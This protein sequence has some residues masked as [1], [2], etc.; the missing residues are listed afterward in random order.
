MEIN[1]IAR[2]NKHVLYSLA[3]VKVLLLDS[4]KFT[5]S[6]QHWFADKIYRAGVTR[7]K[8]LT[9]RDWPESLDQDR[10]VSIPSRVF[11]LVGFIK[12]LPRNPNKY[13]ETVSGMVYENSIVMVSQYV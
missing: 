11:E 9:V 10:V 2:A 3:C 12:F 7:N 13:P 8:P 4:Q 1:K 6:S 5:I